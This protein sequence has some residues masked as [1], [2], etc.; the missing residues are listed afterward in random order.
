MMYRTNSN[1]DIIE[2]NIIYYVL[3][4][5]KPFDDWMVRLLEYSAILSVNEKYVSS[6]ERAYVRHL[7]MRQGAPPHPPREGYAR[8]P[9]QS[10]LS[11]H[12]AL[13]S[14]QWH[15]MKSLHRY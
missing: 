3:K 13:L 4:K 5:K 12:T 7:S 11:A 9:R 2:D 14:P 10:I 15:F 6:I 8:K 1:K